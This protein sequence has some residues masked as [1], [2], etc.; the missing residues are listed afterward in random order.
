MT[1]R[2]HFV[3]QERVDQPDAEAISEFQRQEDRRLV[4]QLVQGDDL[5]RIV[6]GFAVE[7]A[8]IPDSTVTVR[9]VALDGSIGS[10]VGAIA[11][12]GGI[13]DRGA[14]HGGKAPG[15][16]GYL[17]EGAALLLLDF[18]GQP[19]G[20]YDVK[21][22]A[23]IVAGE[24]DNRAFWNPGLNTEFVAGT[25]TRLLPQWEIA[26]TGHADPEW[27]LLAHVTWNAISIAAAQIEDA[28]VFPVDGTPRAAVPVAEQ[29]AHDTQADGTVFGVGDFDRSQARGDGPNEIWPTLR[30]LGRQVQDLK[31]GREDDNRFDWF[32]RPFAPASFLAADPTSKQTKSLR[33]I[34]T[35]TYT[36]APDTTEQGDFNG[37]FAISDCLK[38]IE[39]NAA[40]LPQ[41]IRIIV[42]SRIAALNT[43][44]DWNQGIS[45]PGK[46][47]S[48][49]G[50]GTGYDASLVS[51]VRLGTGVVA[52]LPLSLPSA[53]TMLQMTDGGA[54]YLE[55]IFVESL[56]NLNNSCIDCSLDST[57]AMKNSA[58][59][60][61]AL[62]D[63]SLTNGFALRCADEL[64]D[65]ESSAIAGMCFIGGRQDAGT[66]L[67]IDLGRRGGSVRGT[68]ILGSV[69]LHHHPFNGTTAGDRWAFANRLRFRDCSFV[70]NTLLGGAPRATGQIDARGARHV[71]F[72]RSQ[73]Q[74]SG[75]QNGL[76]IGAAEF[77][78]AAFVPADTI[79]IRECDF[80]MRQGATHAGYISSGGLGGVNGIEGTGWAVSCVAKSG[81]AVPTISEIPKNIRL[82][83]NQFRVD[84]F[85][86][87]LDSSS[88]AG[89]VNLIDT[90]RAVLEGN[91]IINW[92]E[93]TP[94]QT[95]DTQAL[96]SVISTLG[97]TS[98]GKHIWIKD[99][100][101]GRWGEV[102]GALGWGTNLRLIC[103][104]LL[105][106]TDARIEGNIFN[107]D[108]EGFGIIR[109]G[110]K[111]SALYL[112]LC[113]DIDIERNRFQDWRDSASPIFNTC[114]G[115]QYT[116]TRLKFAYNKFIA[117][118]GANI[119]AEAGAG[120]LGRCAFNDNDFAVGTNAL[121]FASAIDLATFY[122]GSVSNV[123]FD[124]NTWDYQGGGGNKDAFF[125][126]GSLNG[127]VLG[128]HVRFGN[129]THATLGGVASANLIGYA[130]GGG[131]AP[132][133]SGVYL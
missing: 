10:F 133:N 7:P 65:I 100:F 9:M 32:S 79:T 82:I 14:S 34:D 43:K 84:I 81:Y 48:I 74:W 110:D 8:A 49:V 22:R 121:L 130:D 102:S 128:N 97:V 68:V 1:R 90:E 96:L 17:L 54:L 108:S 64:V 15:V 6:R 119:V 127:V 58:L 125:I 18:V 37:P 94:G 71:S 42:K 131:P 109:P 19:A 75:D 5:S 2:V 103:L 93:P 62:D 23:T 61:A 56:P 92:R 126:G 53:A 73:F 117:C 59:A 78:V 21:T 33:T 67:N 124:A 50:V 47:I 122:G 120:I 12:G 101:I 28:R 40:T 52:I 113:T 16:G 87:L 114:V 46:A 63:S 38:F 44:Y 89:A 66:S 85:G 91:E 116:N 80:V 27:V 76:R 99:N 24:F 41:T 36:V 11:Y 45:I 105:G 25:N 13:I 31:G 88:D 112:A 51:E 129:I 123:R 72:A 111:P 77:D 98:S 26:F 35:V 30:A 3:S 20:V 29:W 95:L 83:N 57:F 55:N 86:V 115:I 4:R 106:I 60:S 118:G 39:V 132:L 70:T 69:K 104:G 107:A